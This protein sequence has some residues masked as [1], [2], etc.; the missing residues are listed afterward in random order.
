MG[1]KEFKFELHT[2][3]IHS[4]GAFTPKELVESA[5]KHG[6]YG[7]ALTDHNTSSGCREAIEWGKSWE[8]W[9][10]QALSGRHFMAI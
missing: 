1:S 4:D 9:S 3:T 7:I 10:S 8:Y 6:Y 2:H 5:K